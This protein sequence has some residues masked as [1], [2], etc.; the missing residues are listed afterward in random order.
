MAQNNN[1]GILGNTIKTYSG[2]YFDLADPKPEMFDIDTIAT[3]LSRL[4]RFGGNFQTFGHY[5]VGEHCHWAAMLAFNDGGYSA[6]IKAV[7]LHDAAEAYTGDITKPL[8]LMLP[9]FVEI[10]DRIEKVLGER[11]GVDFDK[12]HDLIKHYDLV[13][14]KME[15]RVLFPGDNHEWSGFANIP[16]RNDVMIQGYDWSQMRML[17]LSDFKQLG[18]K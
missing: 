14:L 13:M 18:I 4:P 15:K 17:L 16:D 12:H 8:K 3:V 11:F 10:E 9:E 6:E 5:S 7:L 1:I 2:K